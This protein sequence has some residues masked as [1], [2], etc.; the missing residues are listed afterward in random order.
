V[1]GAAR[2]E[3]YEWFYTAADQVDRIEKVAADDT[4]SVDT[5]YA[6]DADDRLERVTHADGSSVGYAYFPATGR[7]RE[8]RVRP[9]PTAQ[10]QVT[11]YTYDANGNLETAAFRMTPSAT[12]L[13]TTY[14]YDALDRVERRTLPNGVV[15]TWLYDERDRVTELRHARADGTVLL[16][17]AYDYGTPR[18]SIGQPLSVT[19]YEGTAQARRVEYEYD[20]ALRVRQE[21]HRDAAD[22]V[23]ETVE[24]AYDDAGNRTGRVARDSSGS[25]TDT[26]T[27][28]LL[29]GYRLDSVAG[30]ASG[31]QDYAYDAGGRTT[32]IGRPALDGNPALSATLAY[33]AHDNLTAAGGQAYA[34]DAEGRRVSAAG[35]RLVVAPGTVGLENTYAVTDAA[36]TLQAGFVYAGEN[37]LARYDAAGGLTYYLEDA[38]DSVGAVTT[39]GTS[40]AGTVAYDA[41]GNVRASTG[42]GLA[43]AAGAG[44]E[45][46]F[47]GAWRE[48]G[49]GLYHVRARDY[50]PATGRFLT[51]DPAAAVPLAPETLHPYAFANG[52]P[53]L[54]TDPTGEFSIVEINVG[55]LIQGSMQ[56]I[57]A[58]GVNQARRYGIEKAQEFALDILTDALFK[59]VPLGSE[60]RDL[61]EWAYDGKDEALAAGGAWE[62]QIMEYV[63]DDFFGNRLPDEFWIGPSMDWRSGR[64]VND[65]INC[66]DFNAGKSQPI[67][68]DT[69]RP[70]FLVSPIPPSGLH[71][72]GK[73]SWLVGDFKLT[74][75]TLYRDYVHPGKKR[76]QF[77][78]IINHSVNYGTRVS[79]FVTIM[80]AAGNVQ[81]ALHE[82]VRRS[83]LKNG[84][85]TFIISLF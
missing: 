36:G 1:A 71:D 15:T 12:P 40:L 13:T 70:D 19:T 43:G 83:A 45:F 59:V 79:L 22:A 46:G 85:V 39:D 63:C 56:S 31:D 48:A 42:V 14:E 50:D 9:T 76:E 16:R 55:N 11:A 69:K 51:R 64:A 68:A 84:G 18:Q 25:T 33:D 2:L 47:H 52:N 6:Y 29:D 7:V 32:A 38:M 24:Y 41:F 35:R 82:L 28:T 80:P 66:G 26:R 23:V 34:Y 27:S 75:A 73:R 81:G 17:F 78:A 65:G 62:D 54:Y 5:D 74:G 72:S 20:A 58:A 67:V 30:S 3:K 77:E 60:M 37:P 57:R 53:L 44:G 49:T 10:E 61:V 8:V 21:R 4:R